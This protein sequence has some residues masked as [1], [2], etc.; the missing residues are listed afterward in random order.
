[1][2]KLSKKEIKNH[3]SLTYKE[4]QRVREID[5]ATYGQGTI[6]SDLVGWLAF[7]FIAYLF[8]CSP[9]YSARLLGIIIFLISF[10]W[11]ACIVYKLSK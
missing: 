7:L 10:Y 3:Q 2:T 6:Y 1:M 9:Y 5:D 4:R 8:I 11:I